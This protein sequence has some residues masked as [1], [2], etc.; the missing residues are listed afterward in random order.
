MSLNTRIYTH[1][2]AHV[3][4]PDIPMIISYAICTI[5]RLHWNTLFH[6]GLNPLTE[7]S[8]VFAAR[9]SHYNLY[10]SLQQIPVCAG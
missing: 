10:M 3:Y 2:Y 7:F 4:S 5:T 8:V 9:G 6:I 1:I